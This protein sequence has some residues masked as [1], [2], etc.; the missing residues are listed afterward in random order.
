[1]CPRCVSVCLRVSPDPALRSATRNRETPK[2]RIRGRSAQV[3]RNLILLDLQNFVNSTTEGAHH[4]HQLSLGR[5][6]AFLLQPPS[7]FPLLPSPSPLPV[8]LLPSPPYPLQ[9]LYVTEAAAATGT[10]KSG[11]SRRQQRT[12]SVLF[13][14]ILL[15]ARSSWVQPS[16]CR[17]EDRRRPAPTKGASPATELQQQREDLCRQG[18][19]LSRYRG[20]K[21]PGLFEHTSVRFRPID[22]PWGHTTDWRLTSPYTEQATNFRIRSFGDP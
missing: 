12:R 21:Q 16:R 18:T 14:R 3:Q 6:F 20:F 15:A 22:D 2:G 17:G 11:S 19:S 4:E 1:M 7:R 10:N 8:L 5:S 13:A 9:V